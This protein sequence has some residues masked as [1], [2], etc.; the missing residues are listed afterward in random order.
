MKAKNLD[1]T[2]QGRARSCLPCL[3]KLE[4]RLPQGPIQVLAQRASGQP[5][6]G[7]S[8]QSASAPHFPACPHHFPPVPPTSTRAL[9]L[10][11]C[12]RSPGPRGCQL[13]RTRRMREDEEGFGAEE[14]Q[15]G[16]VWT[17]PKSVPNSTDLGREGEKG[18]RG[19][20]NSG[21]EGG[22]GPPLAAQA[23]SRL[24]QHTLQHGPRL[25]ARGP[26]RAPL[27][28]DPTR[29]AE[30]FLSVYLSH[31]DNVLGSEISDAPEADSSA[32]SFMRSRL[33]RCPEASRTVGESQAG[34][35][36]GWLTRSPALCRKGT[37]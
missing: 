15:A 22:L 30:H 24:A 25:P 20:R 34:P 12:S 8:G 16:Q 10:H 6:P 28:E 2:L 17:G 36:A 7:A 1:P 27:T 35:T 14:L 37:A 4:A 19:E 33:R 3:P 32:V 9:N 18:N 5:G 26:R 31:T 23:A 21:M 29:P 11:P 13:G